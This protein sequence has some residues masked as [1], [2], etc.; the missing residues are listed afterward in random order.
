MTPGIPR[1]TFFQ[2][3][4]ACCASR[5]PFPL[6]GAEHE[7]DSLG[8]WTNYSAERTG[9]YYLKEIAGR[10]WFI[11]PLGHVFLPVG[12]NHIHLRYY[13]QSFNR[14][15]MWV[16]KYGR[17]AERVVAAVL[18]NMK[19][20]G[21]N[22]IG[23][24]DTSIPPGAGRLPYAVTVNFTRTQDPSP[25]HS[26]VY[27]D[28]FSTPFRQECEKLAGE[29][30]KP[31]ADDPLLMGIYLNDVP[32][33]DRETAQWH[34]QKDWVQVIASLDRRSP[35]KHKYV[36]VM[37]RRYDSN[38]REFNQIYGTDFRSFDELLDRPGRSRRNFV[39]WGRER[40]DVDV[41][42]GVI[43]SK[44][45]EVLTGAIRK[46]DRNHLVL[47]DRYNGNFLIPEPVI[48]AMKPYVDAF[49]VQYY[50]W[51]EKQKPHLEKWREISGKP[52]MLCDSCFA[53]RNEH[54]PNPVGPLVRNP[55]QRGE[56]YAGYLREAMAIP[57]VVG[58]NWCGYV[59]LWKRSPKSWRQKSGFLDPFDNEEP[60]F[61][62][63]VAAANARL[64]EYASAHRAL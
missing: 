26:V 62:S 41:F 63:R 13:Q 51:L 15:K 61:T 28:V 2:T 58:W 40:Q 21:F 46:F 57:Y 23:G 14:Q 37:R 64:Y 22:S 27:P 52:I 47:G 20:W 54:M 53:I 48:E 4:L 59:E 56:A 9:F 24:L 35:G 34:S 49:S 33:W 42:L 30:L 55:T 16:E 45:Y 12:I 6:K 18:R 3:C 31:L 43:A 32:M 7:L 50:G 11:N 10:W 44:Y 39:E 38:V 60:Q 29:R 1:R 8:G 5:S 36:E 17:S 25:P 19:R